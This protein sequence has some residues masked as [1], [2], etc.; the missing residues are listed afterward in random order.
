M[1]DQN[2]LPRALT[3]A[4]KR[5][6]R[7]FSSL[8]FVASMFTFILVFGQHSSKQQQGGMNKPFVRDLCVSSTL[9]TSGVSSGHCCL[10]GLRFTIFNPMTID[11]KCKKPWTSFKKQETYKA[12]NL[13]RGVWESRREKWKPSRPISIA[14]TASSERNDGLAPSRESQS[15]P[16]RVHFS[17]PGFLFC[18][19]ITAFST[20]LFV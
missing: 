14:S 7:P 4:Y 1:P 17:H 6:S 5:K 3:N 15:A 12:Q 13:S 8:S 18:H 16:S 11:T 10:S 2:W 19:W 9:G 20:Y